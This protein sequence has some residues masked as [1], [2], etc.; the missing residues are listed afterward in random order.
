MKQLMLLVALVAITSTT[1]TVHSASAPVKQVIAGSVPGVVMTSFNNQV[2][3]LMEN[4]FPSNPA[5]NASEVIWTHVKGN[6]V[7]QGF[8]A[9]VGGNGAGLYITAGVFKNTGE[10]VSF[11]Y[12]VVP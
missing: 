10:K 7:A 3:A 9:Q 2:V 1:G 5:Y 8:V 11:N 12:N 4:W 6:W